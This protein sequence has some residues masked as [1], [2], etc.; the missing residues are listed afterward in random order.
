MRLYNIEANAKLFYL[1]LSIPL[2]YSFF[3]FSSRWISILK[4][5]TTYDM[6]HNNITVIFIDLIRSGTF[7]IFHTA[8]EKTAS[9]MIRFAA[10]N[11]KRTINLFYQYHAHHLVWE[12]H[13]A[14]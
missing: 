1:I 12:G 6:F 2:S 8:S 10:H 14:E 5:H 4:N 13:F 7:K 3:P 11:L 9:F